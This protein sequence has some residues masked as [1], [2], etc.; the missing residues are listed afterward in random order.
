MRSFYTANK[1][2][3]Y[4][5]DYRQLTLPVEKDPFLKE[6]DN[7]LKVAEKEPAV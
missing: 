2:D 5:S 4:T 1:I 7:F 6:L 3:M